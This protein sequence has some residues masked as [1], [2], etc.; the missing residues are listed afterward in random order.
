MKTFNTYFASQEELKQFIKENSI[1]DS[2]SLLIQVFTSNNDETFISSLT[3]FINEILPLSSLIGSTTDGEIKDGFVSSSETVI[4][5]T[6]FEKTL[7]KTYISDSFENF[8]EAGT[9]LA[10][11]L[12]E[13]KLKAIIAFTD[14][15]K[16]NGEDFLNGID[17]VCKDVIVA[18][19]LAGDKA[20]FQRT[21][22]FTKDK[23]FQ[24]GVVGIGLSSSSLNVY[25]DYSFN[26]FS[27]GMN[28]KIT[29]AIGNRVYTINDKTAYEIY[30][31]YLGEDTARA[32]PESAIE[33]P[34]IINRNGSDIARMV[35]SS[36][37]DG[38]LIFGGNFKNGD[39]VRFAYGDKAAI[40]SDAK[41][42][43]KN[44]AKN[45]IESVFI[46]SSMARKR[47][48]PEFIE[49]ET[50][51]FNKIAPTAGFFTYGEFYTSSSKEFLNQSM[52]IFALSESDTIDKSINFTDE[53]ELEKNEY[54]SIK[55]LSHFIKVSS[56]ELEILNIKL[57]NKVEDEIEKNRDKTKQIIE[58]KKIFEI[59]FN[60]SKDGI[61]ILENDEFIDCNDAAFNMLNYKS[62]DELLYKHPSQLSPEFQPDGKSSFEKLKENTIKCIHNGSHNFE[63]VYTKENGDDFWVD[64][65]LSDITRNN[66]TQFFVVW[67]DI[68]EKKRIDAKLEKLNLA[69]KDR[70]DEEIK[71]NI[72]IEKQRQELI[73]AEDNA[74]HASSAKSSFLA[75]MS[76][77]IRTP[78]NAIMGFIDILIKNET[79]L[80]KKSKLDIIKQ[81]SN[82]LMEVINDIL[83]FSKIESGK[84]SIEKVLFE[85]KDPF[86]VTTELFYDKAQE[87]NIRLNLKFDDKLQQIGYG[88]TT[89]IKQIY[90]NLLSNAIKFSDKNSD[91]DIDILFNKEEHGIECSVK[92]SG[93][94]IKP[95]N[96]TK[97][98]TAFEQ[99]DSS[100]TRRFGGTGLGLSICKKLT[101]LMGGKL[102]VKSV[103]NHGSTFTFSIDIFSNMPD[104]EFKKESEVKLEE[105]LFEGKILVVEDNKTNQLLLIAF[106]EE[107]GLDTIV[108]ANDGL[109]ALE[110]YNNEQ[111]SLILMDENMPNMNG[112]QATKHIRE[113]ESKKHSTTPIVAVTANAL[114]NDKKR[115]LDAG[116]DDYI[117]K[118]IIY[119]EL[120]RVLA[121]YLLK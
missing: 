49:N 27:M 44:V 17:S 11:N 75:N 47:F 97:V 22:V 81:S 108:V 93:I 46:Y 68:D 83:D 113:L 94:G 41:Q 104:K 19:G 24:N 33:F 15:I 65:I 86:I 56:N 1:L 115:F 120:K 119:T 85:T 77:E 117:S 82:V 54:N 2:K 61:L 73:I 57:E 87:K 114:V 78:M 26:W 23:V 28:L 60:K 20:R 55:T 18:G 52:T 99:E 80:E 95:E 6:V 42:N 76:H 29:K 38:S 3:A 10:N 62:K 72:E 13:P 89:R 8:F 66:Q 71:K 103:F 37:D 4:S 5:F 31:Y 48:M 40:L 92:D 35:I 16:G 102:E 96:I 69:L 118:P 12:N 90:S 116:M 64:V 112:I 36:E 105:V 45:S 21:Y 106:L 79:S 63:W 109:E 50:S 43:I 110:A 70:V 111:F 59:I 121:K 74:K 53:K 58:Q 107:F 9:S 67:R 34:L 51:L 84:L 101:E 7:L 14:G 32:L 39:T 91:I 98:F 25:T 100:I 30:A 88:D